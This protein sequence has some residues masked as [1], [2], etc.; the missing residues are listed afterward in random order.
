MRSI[1]GVLFL[2]CCLGCP[3]QD[4]ADGGSGSKVVQGIKS[5]QAP[6]PVAADAGPRVVTF[7]TAG[8]IQAWAVNRPGLGEVMRAVQ[9]GSGEELAK[10]LQKYPSVDPELVARARA[11]AGR[12]PISEQAEAAITGP[13]SLPVLGEHAP[14]ELGNTGI[15]DALKEG[16]PAE[17]KE[18]LLQPGSTGQV[19]AGFGRTRALMLLK[20][21]ELK[22]YGDCVARVKTSPSA[23]E[24]VRKELSR[25]KALLLAGEREEVAVVLGL[26]PP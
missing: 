8:G 7:V 12:G 18:V 11:V 14:V 15:P 10:V 9:L 21:T 13:L 25:L 6:T 19:L 5:I 4:A 24:T 2:V 1:H 20:G 26:G 22:R 23:P 16:G 17:C 3:R